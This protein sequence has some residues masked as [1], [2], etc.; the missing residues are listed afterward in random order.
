MCEVASQ[1]IYAE[2][3]L[4]CAWNKKQ[5]KCLKGIQDRSYTNK[6]G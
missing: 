4:T 3:A 5:R 2:L 6:L 1:L